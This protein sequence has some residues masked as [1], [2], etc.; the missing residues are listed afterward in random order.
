MNTHRVTLTA[1]FI[2]LV[3]GSSGFVQA[4]QSQ[5]LIYQNILEPLQ[6]QFPLPDFQSGARRVETPQR[7]HLILIDAPGELDKEDTEYRLTRNVI[8]NGTAFRVKA[9]RV[10]LNLNGHTVIYNE[11]SVGNG[12]FVDKWWAEDVAILNGTLAQGAAKN[13]GGYHSNETSP[14]RTLHCRRLTVAGLTI[15]YS[16]PDMVGLFIDGCSGAHIHDNTIID[17]GNVVTNRHQGVDVIRVVGDNAKIHNNMISRAR[18]IGIRSGSDAEVFYNEVHIDSSV[19]NSTGISTASG[20]VHHNKIYGQGVHPIGIWPGNNIK[21][22]SNYIRVQSTKPGDEYGSTGAACLRLMWGSNTN[23]E[24]YGNTMILVAEEDYRGSKFNSWGRCVWVGVPDPKQQVKFH[25][26]L[27]IAFN[28]DGKAKA[29][30]VAIC[31][32]DKNVAFNNLEFRS[33]V[34][35]S[36]WTNLLLADSYGSAGGY[37]RFVGNRFVR[38]GDSKT[39]RTVRSQYSS[40]PSTALLID[41]IFENGASLKLLDMELSGVATKELAIGW[42]LEV[43]VVRSQRPVKHVD[44]TLFNKYGDKVTT[45]KT[46]ES[47][48]A[49]FEVVTELIT[50]GINSAYLVKPVVDLFKSTERQELNPHRVLVSDNGETFERIIMVTSPTTIVF[51][52]SGPVVQ[53]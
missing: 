12:V 27:I 50:N 28:T 24:V 41:N 14:I 7:K 45:V 51:D 10:T 49:V 6:K 3:M 37:S 52:L 17:E 13:S 30:A 9:H 39:Y 15:R 11:K 31:G 18:H 36:N 25:D 19:T 4:E 29:A 32:N 35:V 42:S 34:I 23:V 43:K 20:T 26:N 8:A 38:L 5:L 33:N 46:D 44:V 22:Y 53:L 16:G 2:F 40:I 48:V 1:L 47:G 21:V